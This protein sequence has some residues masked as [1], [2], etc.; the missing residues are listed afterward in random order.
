M[1]SI[2][3]AAAGIG[4]ACLSFLIQIRPRLKNRDFGVD[5]WRHLDEA[6]VFRRNR[7]KLGATPGRYLIEKPTDYPPLIRL[8]LSIIPKKTLEKYEWTVAP[9]FDAIQNILLFAVVWSWTRRLDVAV[10]A[11]LM[12][13]LSPLVIMENS[14][15]TTRSF[16]CLL[17]VCGWLPL[18]IHLNGGPIGWLAVGVF[19]FGLLFLAH[20]LAI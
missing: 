4:V 6:D 7:R 18:V 11:Q 2:F 17:F 16:A 5:S 10:P 13:C 20:R 9:A 12:Y 3:G 15:L 14:N 1:S 19:F 8:V